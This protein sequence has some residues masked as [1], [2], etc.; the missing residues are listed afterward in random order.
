MIL[1]VFSLFCRVFCCCFFAETNVNTNLL[2]Q[3]LVFRTKRVRRVWLNSSEGLN[4]WFFAYFPYFFSLFFCQNHHE[5][6]SVLLQMWGFRTKSARRLCLTS[7]GFNER[8]VV[9]FTILSIFFGQNPSRVLIKMS[10]LKHEIKGASE[11][12]PS[13]QCIAEKEHEF[14]NDSLWFFNRW[15]SWCGKTI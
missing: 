2:P 3:I 12:V 6:I 4:K 15:I 9:F 1:R 14:G 8:F 11:R 10:V 5:Y 7:D 13:D